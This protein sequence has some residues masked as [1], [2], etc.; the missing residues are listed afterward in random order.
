MLL[1]VLQEREVR[2]VGSARVVTVDVRVVAATNRDLDQAVRERAFRA[3]LLDRLREIVVEVPPLRARTRDIPELVDHFIRHQLRRHGI[4]MPSIDARTMRGLEAYA[5]PGNVR[6]LEQAV[7]RAVVLADGDV[8]RE[9]DLGL[10]LDPRRPTARAASDGHP[11]VP[12]ASDGDPTSRFPGRGEHHE[13]LTTR[14]A[15]AL[16]HA[17]R[18]GSVR[19]ADLIGRFGISREAARRDLV[20]LVRLGALER[21]GACRGTAYRP[22]TVRPR[23]SD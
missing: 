11:G 22:V 15:F 12:E 9:R 6:E 20:A 23:P 14:Q 21:W 4:A 16:A 18:H 17:E 5:W 1:R 13:R 10:P 19:R 2:P 7:S 8:I 3:D